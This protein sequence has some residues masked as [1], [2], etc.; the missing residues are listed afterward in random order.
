MADLEGKAFSS[1]IYEQIL[2]LLREYKQKN[3]K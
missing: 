1:E 3:G 2:A